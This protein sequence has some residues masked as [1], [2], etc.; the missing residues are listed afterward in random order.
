M[1]SRAL[2]GQPQE[3][4]WNSN[5]LILSPHNR[6]RYQRR[7]AHHSLPARK[8]DLTRMTRCHL[9][10]ASTRCRTHAKSGSQS[11]RRPPIGAKPRE[12][13]GITFLESITQASAHMTS[14]C[15]T[16]QVALHWAAV[17]HRTT[18]LCVTEIWIQLLE[19]SRQNLRHVCNQ[20]FRSHLKL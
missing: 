9:V 18:S 19:R 14:H 5:S 15:S 10:P 17:A 13:S 2:R 16:Q 20:L 12:S 4:T 8:S 6:K 7:I 1:P 3:I 11:T